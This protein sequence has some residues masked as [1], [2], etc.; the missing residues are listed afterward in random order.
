[1]L[2]FHCS[3]FPGSIF[4]HDVT[5][6]P[7]DS[8]SRF[9]RIYSGR[10]P[11]LFPILFQLAFQFHHIRVQFLFT[12]TSA[13][14]PVHRS[15]AR[16]GDFP[17]TVN[18]AFRHR[19]LPPCPSYYLAA[20]PRLSSPLLYTCRPRPSS[21]VPAPLQSLRPHSRL[22]LHPRLGATTPR[23]HTDLGSNW[24]SLI[25]HFYDKF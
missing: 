25:N 7:R 23:A 11:I 16:R 1:M 9:S 22:P 2:P 21:S 4:F 18:L 5:S 3:D 13:H 6:I 15:T 8:I 24:T 19:F 14:S 12:S 20:S 17:R 10:F